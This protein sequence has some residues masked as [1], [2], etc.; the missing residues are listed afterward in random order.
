MS[1][2]LGCHVHQGILLKKCAVNIFITH[3]FFSAADFS[4]NQW[5]QSR[6]ITSATLSQFDS[7]LLMEN[8]GVLGYLGA[9]Q[10]SSTSP[11]SATGWVDG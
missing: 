3:G 5:K 4:L 7:D 10:C 6:G 1:V 2:C 8:L 9:T 11:Q